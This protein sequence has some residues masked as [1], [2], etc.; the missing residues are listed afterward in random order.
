MRVG[1]VDGELAFGLLQ[2]SGVE[3]LLGLLV[4]DLDNGIF[5]IDFIGEVAGGFTAIVVAG[6][7]GDRPA[8]ELRIFFV[9][10]VSEAL[11]TLEGDFAGLL[12]EAGEAIAVGALLFVSTLGG[13][14]VG[15]HGD[16][17]AEAI[18]VIS[19]PGEWGIGNRIRAGFSVGRMP[20]ATVDGVDESGGGEGVGAVVELIDAVANG[21]GEVL[22][23]AEVGGVGAAD[24]AKGVVA[25]GLGPGVGVEVREEPVG[26]TAVNVDGATEGSLT[27]ND[28]EVGTGPVL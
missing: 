28:F 1:G 22:V 26:G 6:V 7:E 10:D 21:N 9:G 4:D 11:V 27:Q 20:P 17:V 19:G 13:V 16:F 3:D 23:A 2:T 14:G 5:E 18:E 25:T 24:F 12:V 15:E 8:G